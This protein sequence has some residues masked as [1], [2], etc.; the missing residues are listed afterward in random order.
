MPN[1]E[2][3]ITCVGASDE[4]IA[5]LRLLMRK[6][7]PELTHAWRWGSE[8]GADLV[9]VDPGD[10]AGQMARTRAQASGIRHAVI[11]AAGAETYGVLA[12]E[13]PFRLANVVD[14][15]NEVTRPSV[16]APTIV[17]TRQ[18]FY[19]EEV[20]A[21][22][23]LP[24]AATTPAPPSRRDDVALGL[25]EMIRGNPLVDPFANA[26]PPIGADE[27][28]TIDAGDGP[29][30]R[31]EA[32]VER[33]PL[34][35]ADEAA[36][37]RRYAPAPKRISPEDLAL[38]PLR[39]Y[40]AGDLLGG[41][42]RFALPGEA[43]LVLDPKNQVFHA[44]ARLPALEVYCREPSRRSDWQALTSTEIAQL[45]DAQAAQ[46]YH[47]LQWLDA[48]LRS[49]GRLAAHLDPGG[50]YTLQRW[51][52]ILR[53]YPRQARISTTMMQ[54]LRLHE[55]VAASGAEMAEVFDVVNAYDAIGWL[56][57]K[58]RP[59]RHD[60]GPGDSGLGAFVQRLRKPF[61]R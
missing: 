52:D 6:A 37:P 39:E 16:V 26:R 32:R 31:S 23:E 3:I 48:F 53:D 10:F 38:R 28:V 42:A 25:D 47:K 8:V 29:T 15:L 2:K 46:P 61:T 5:H 4:D 44:D 35:P 41:P 57:W 51:L 50:T 1:S 11:C 49:G 27:T 56:E 45:R 21:T 40:L 13:R 54:P 9:V 59:R 12:F 19:F 34:R 30:R 33:D 55:I 58:P 17:P 36:P 7:A 60:D 14:V 20:G 43:P 18:E 22:P 24:D